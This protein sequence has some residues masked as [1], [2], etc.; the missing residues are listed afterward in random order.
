MSFFVFRFILDVQLAFP[1]PAESA[2]SAR[3]L[4]K[5]WSATTAPSRALELLS[6]EEQE[7]VLR[8]FRP[9]DAALAL[10]SCLLKRLA[11][12]KGASVTWHEAGSGM[13]RA[14]NGKPIWNGKEDCRM[15]VEFNISHHGTMVV[16]I[17]AAAKREVAH[18][19]RRVGIDITRVNVVKDTLA[20]RR[21]GGFDRWVQ[22]F[23]EVIPATELRHIVSGSSST[24]VDIEENL[25]VKLRRFY[26]H[27]TLREAYVKVSGRSLPL[28]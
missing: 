2:D 4:T 25:E 15:S 13:K 20:V 11:V 10:G 7:A 6:T 27:W 5:D 19:T 24:V 8:F 21:E 23:K 26:A 1:I 28:G 17:A 9:E 18:N 14:K 3:T 12:V 16:L 22:I